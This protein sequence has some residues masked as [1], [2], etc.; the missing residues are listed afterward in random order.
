MSELR[1]TDFAV[2]LRNTVDL[3]KPS[4]FFSQDKA[5]SIFKDILTNETEAYNVMTFVFNQVCTLSKYDMVHF[6]LPAIQVLQRHKIMYEPEDSIIKNFTNG[7]LVTIQV[8]PSLHRS[9]ILTAKF[10]IRFNDEK[11]YEILD[12]IELTRFNLRT[13]AIKIPE[14]LCNKIPFES[15]EYIR[16]IQRPEGTFLVGN[17]KDFTSELLRPLFI[18]YLKQFCDLEEIR[19]YRCISS[20][21]VQLYKTNPPCEKIRDFT[22][23][24]NFGREIRGLGCLDRCYSSRSDDI[25]TESFLNDLASDEEIAVYTFGLSDLM[26]LDSSCEQLAQDTM[27][28]KKHQNVYSSTLYNT[29]HYSCLLEWVYL[30]KYLIDLYS[31]LLSREI[32]GEHST[33][34]KMLELQ[35][36][37]MRDLIAYRSGITPYPSREEFLE[38]ARLSHRIPELQEKLEKKR[39]LATDYVI[40]E[41]TLR[42]NKSIQLVNIF[43]SATAAFN[44]MQVVLE[45]K[46]SGGAIGFWTFVTTGMFIATLALLWVVNKFVMKHR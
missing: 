40:Q 14:Q 3:G 1:I 27:K 34:E 35:K 32:A 17:L 26:I 6:E 28:N 25:V 30:E 24:S 41:Y 46:Q 19:D 42:T 8:Y 2:T 10:H 15:K 18:H 5:N 7:S 11:G 4:S 29:T 23:T 38:K 44:L 13:L 20:T 22:L 9:G 31:V 45:I 16:W 37:S 21:L 36:Q 43:I 12:A 39:D 33:P